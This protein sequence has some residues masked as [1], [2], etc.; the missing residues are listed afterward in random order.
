MSLGV[1]AGTGLVAAIVIIVVA[2]TLI[3][4]FAH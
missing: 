1:L 2:I 3:N 4:K